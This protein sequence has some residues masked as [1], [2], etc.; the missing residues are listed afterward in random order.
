MKALAQKLKKALERHKEIIDFVLFGSTVKGKIN[1][2]DLDIA[3][4][5][6]GMIER[7]TVKKEIEQ[8]LQKKIDLQV[9]TIDDYDKFIWIT[10][11]RE[12]Y[13]VKNQQYIYERQG[14]K[15]VVLYKYSLKPLGA[16]KKVMFERA[17]KNFKGV[18]RLSNRVVIV[19]VKISREFSDFLKHWDIDLESQEYGLLPLV[20]K[21]EF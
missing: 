21:E 14:I 2:S 5:S 1:A 4:I 9:V 18:A 13:S 6:K 19:P 16:S 12:G 20:R 8:T 7:G 10:L 17:L 15:P 11:L 3:V